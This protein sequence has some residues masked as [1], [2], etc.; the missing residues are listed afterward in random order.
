MI[1]FVT[2]WCVKRCFS[3]SFEVPDVDAAVLLSA[4]EDLIK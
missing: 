4:V 3:V 2:V 1:P